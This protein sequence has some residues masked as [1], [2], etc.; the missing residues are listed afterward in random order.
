VKEPVCYLDMDGVL[1]DFVK[2]AHAVHQAEYRPE[3]IKW[4]FWKALGLTEEAFWKPCGFKFWENLPWTLEGKEL[5]KHITELFGT[6][7]VLLT[8]PSLNL[9]AVEGKI[10]WVRRELPEFARRLFVGSAKDMLAGPSKILVDD[11]DANLA[12]F[13]KEGGVVV[14]VPRPWNN[15]A[16]YCVGAGGF[17]VRRLMNH[18][19]QAVTSVLPGEH[20]D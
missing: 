4:D 2:G 1:V 20:V 6:R 18:I 9:G 3:D 16:G 10:A 5:V 14:P 15:R 8:S 12:A 17:D 7:V 19:Y 11:S 13:E